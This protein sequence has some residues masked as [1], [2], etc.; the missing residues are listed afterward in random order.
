MWNSFE[1]GNDCREKLMVANFPGIASGESIMRETKTLLILW[2]VLGVVHKLCCASHL[3][4]LNRTLQC[5]QGT[6]RKS[7]TPHALLC[8]G[9]FE[10]RRGAGQGGDVLKDD[11]RRERAPALIFSRCCNS[12]LECPIVFV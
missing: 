5:Y 8:V 4:F 9:T 3:G 1:N 10:I 6:S 7:F 12:M 2:A 11:H